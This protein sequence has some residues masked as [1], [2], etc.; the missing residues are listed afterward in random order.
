MKRDGW[1][2]KEDLW[3]WQHDEWRLVVSKTTTRGW[4]WST[5]VRCERCE[6]GDVVGYE[7]TSAAAKAAALEAAKRLAGGAA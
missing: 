3:V 4:R 5:R 2:R 6:R 1:T 7:R